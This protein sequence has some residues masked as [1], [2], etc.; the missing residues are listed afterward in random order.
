[1][2]I[3]IEARIAR[4]TVGI[5]ERSQS[6]TMTLG[7]FFKGYLEECRNPRVRDLAAY[8]RF[9]RACLARVEKVAPKIALLQLTLLK[10][11]HIAKLRDALAV[12]YPA[13]TVRTTLIHVSA[14]LS[15]ELRKSSSQPIRSKVWRVHQGHHRG[16][17]F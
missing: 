15:W 6:T 5:G 17:I 13:G 8:R 4:G 3:E 14:A 9:A 11:N 12:C 16:S 1:M 2:L 10:S 7:V